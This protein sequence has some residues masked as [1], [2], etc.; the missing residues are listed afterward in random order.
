M[1]SL[2]TVFDKF[3]AN[4]W[5][6]TKHKVTAD[7]FNA[8][9]KWS[10]CE[11]KNL[12]E[13]ESWSRLPYPE[14]PNWVGEHTLGIVSNKSGLTLTFKTWSLINVHDKKVL[15]SENSASN[16]QMSLKTL[17][18]RLQI[19]RKLELNLYYHN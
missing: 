13:F 14:E 19:I 6:K 9:R 7:G 4:T 16:S 11:V 18:R 15:F 12:T 5:N 3:V 1:K 8:E 2:P 17:K 10:I